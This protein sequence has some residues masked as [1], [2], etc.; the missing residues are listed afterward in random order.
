MMV[1]SWIG[2]EKGI[3]SG[4]GPFGLIM[5]NSGRLDYNYST[6]SRGCSVGFQTCCIAD[7]QIGRALKKW[8]RPAGLETRDTADL[9]VNACQA[10]AR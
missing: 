8:E 2:R 4:L 1:Q 6:G 5:E 9:E 7:F 3:H 10:K